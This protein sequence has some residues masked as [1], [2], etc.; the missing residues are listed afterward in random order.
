MKLLFSNLFS[1]HDLAAGDIGLSFI[2]QS[3]MHGLVAG[4]IYIKFRRTELL[5]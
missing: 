1:I 3:S 5:F 2:N 4:D